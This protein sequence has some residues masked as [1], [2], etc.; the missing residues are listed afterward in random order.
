MDRFEMTILGLWMALAA[1]IP[2]AVWYSVD[3]FVA[4]LVR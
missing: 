2:I 3:H 4:A 1:A